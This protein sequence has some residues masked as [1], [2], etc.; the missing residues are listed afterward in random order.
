MELI[1]H[2]INEP[3]LILEQSVTQR[4]VV[5]ADLH[6]G[7]ENTLIDKGVEIPSQVQT[8][9]LVK[10]LEKIIKRVKPTGIIILGDIKH[11]IPMISHMEWYIVP[12]FFETF[13]NLPIH[14]ILGN[15]ES[16]TQI[17]GLTTRNV[18]EGG[19]VSLHTAVSSIFFH[20]L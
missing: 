9:R 19:S 1:K 5:I 8:Q 17:E 16:E 20:R 7:I 15:H 13:T 3:A 12:P 4:F 18:V 11:N 10:K 6:L 2:L 14:V